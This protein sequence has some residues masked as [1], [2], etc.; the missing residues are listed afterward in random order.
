MPNVY[1]H[2]LPPAPFEAQRIPRY[3]F[4]MS[5]LPLQS[6][7]RHRSGRH[8]LQVWQARL[9]TEKGKMNPQRAQ[10]IHKA[11]AQWE[12]RRTKQEIKTT[13]NPPHLG[14]RTIPSS[15]SC[16]PRAPPPF[17][18]DPPLRRPESTAQPSDPAMFRQ[19]A[20]TSTPGCPP[21]RTLA[22]LG[23]PRSPGQGPRRTFVPRVPAS[24]RRAHLQCPGFGH[25]PGNHRRR[26]RGCAPHQRE[27]R[28]RLRSRRRHRRSARRSQR[29][30]RGWRARTRG[31]DP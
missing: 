16:K 12:E 30:R 26:R 9:A 4:L 31:P 28:T 15:V 21:S 6:H 18:S 10:K 19:P 27:H 2:P 29:I 11:K 23:G 17:P 8:S 22:C 24:Y 5:G 25:R 7:F 14:T 20:R 1:S 3:C 13:R